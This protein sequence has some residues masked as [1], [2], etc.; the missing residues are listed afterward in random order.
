MYRKGF[1]TDRLRITNGS[2]NNGEEIGFVLRCSSEK[3]DA[4]P[5]LRHFE[6]EE[7][8]G[9]DVDPVDGVAD[10][11]DGGILSDDGR[12]ERRQRRVVEARPVIRQGHALRNY[13]QVKKRV[14]ELI[15]S[16]VWQEIGN[17]AFI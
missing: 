11:R 4:I 10:D 5:H 7:F 3:L 2:T 15:E 17:R 12:V 1:R 8:S 9:G 6:S 16:Y 14:V 13:L